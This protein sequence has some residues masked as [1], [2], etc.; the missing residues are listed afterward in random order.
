M[1]VLLFEVM[2][3]EPTL[4][5]V[6]CVALVIGV[7]GF[8]LSNYKYQFIVLILPIALYISFGLLRE[9][10]DEFVGSAILRE[11]G[12]GYVIQNYLAILI[13]IGFPIIG[14]IRKY[15]QTRRLTKRSS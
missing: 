3:K 13:M 14:T 6:W 9:I 5:L 15:L 2:D 12:I 7:G 8:F 4:V 11:A 10:H 1:I